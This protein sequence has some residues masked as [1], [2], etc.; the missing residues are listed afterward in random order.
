MH[1]KG[2]IL[3]IQD[4]TPV[5]AKFTCEKCG[6]EGAICDGLFNPELLENK[7]ILP[8]DIPMCE[9]CVIVFPELTGFFTRI[10]HENMW[11]MLDPKVTDLKKVYDEDLVWQKDEA[12]VEQMRLYLKKNHFI[13]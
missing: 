5:M 11:W 12:A 2:K 8:K 7:D 4:G 6:H 9:Y 10:P 3:G 13:T 1:I